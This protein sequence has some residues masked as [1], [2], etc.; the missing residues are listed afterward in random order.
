MFDNKFMLS[1]IGIVLVVSL[2]SNKINANANTITEGFAGG[3]SMQ[4]KVQRTI[5]CKNGADFYSV[6]SNFQPMLAPRMFS[7][8]YGANIKYNIP[9]RENLAVPCNPLGTTDGLSMG[10]MVTE[11]Y[12]RRPNSNSGKVKENYGCSGGS[13]LTC[14]RMGTSSMP[15]SQAN[16][17]INQSGYTAGNFSNVMA[18][19]QNMMSDTMEN[20]C[21]YPEISSMMPVASMETNNGLGEIGQVVVYDRY[22]YANRNSRLR[23]QGDPIRGDLPIVPCNAEWFRPSVQPNIDLQAGALSVLG[24]YDNSQGQKM[25]DLI[26]Y[27]SGQTDNTIAGINM[28]DVNMADMYQTNF[29]AGG[30]DINV[31]AFP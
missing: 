5:G 9:S 16:P 18:E 27:S 1:L 23:S 22:V 17:L 20:G 25:A 31:T 30:N 21:P 10:R 13:G 2:V 15:Y 4:V 29:N 14:G 7:G 26:N 24:G 19:S 6:P 12:E 11:N 8:S 3:P 28:A